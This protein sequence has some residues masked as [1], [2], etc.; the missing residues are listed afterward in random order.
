MHGPALNCGSLL[1]IN[2]ADPKRSSQQS[3]SLN[4]SLNVKKQVFQEGI[5]SGAAACRRMTANARAE[6]I[7]LLADAVHLRGAAGLVGTGTILIQVLAW[8][9]GWRRSCGRHRRCSHRVLR[10]MGWWHGRVHDSSKRL[11]LMPHRLVRCHGQRP[12][13]VG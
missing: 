4:A 13:P 1:R 8:S 10:R 6:H 3:D 2:Q 7:H 11:L 12:R 9:L 5:R